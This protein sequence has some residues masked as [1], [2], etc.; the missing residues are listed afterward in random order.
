MVPALVATGFLLTRGARTQSE[1]L[2]P[3][4]EQAAANLAHHIDR[5]R[6]GSAL[7]PLGLQ[8]LYLDLDAEQLVNTRV[9]WGTPLPRRPLPE[10]DDAVRTTLKPYYSDVMVGAVAQRPVVT[11][12]AAFPQLFAGY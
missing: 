11:P 9:P 10:I 4:I 6:A 8:L 5:E 3:R 2:D 7:H 12:T 1:Q